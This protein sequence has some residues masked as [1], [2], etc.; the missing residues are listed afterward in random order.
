MQPKVSLRDFYV[1]TKLDQSYEDA[2]L[3]IRPQVWVD[4]KETELKNYTVKAQLYDAENNPVLD[5]MPSANLHSIYYERWPQR[6]L[7]KFGLLSAKVRLPYKWTA[8]TPYLY[9]LVLEVIDNNNKVIEARSQK[10]GF[11]KVEFSKDNELLI[12]GKVTEI[13]GVNRHDHSAVNG[14]ALTREEME[15][16]VKLLK[17]YNFNSVRTSHYP[18]DPYFLELCNEYGIYVMDEANIETHHLGSYMP[19]QPM[20]AGAM[21]SRIIRMVER[22]KNNPSIISWSLGNEAGTGPIFAAAAGWIKDF[23]PTRFIH[24]EGAQG[25]PTHPLYDE[26]AAF[27]MGKS[28]GYANPDDPA[29][30]D[31]ISRMYP[32]LSQLVSM[33]ENG[34]MNRPIIMCEY[35]HAMGNSM[36]GLHDYWK[37]I[38]SR[39]NL[40]G[41]YIWDMIDQ[42]IERTHE[43]GQKYFAYGGDFGD[44]PNDGSFCINGVFSADRKPHPHAFE[45]KYLFQP[46]V[47][48]LVKGT[49]NKVYVLNRFTHSDLNQYEVRWELHQDGKILNKGI[50]PTIHLA[51]GTSKIVEIGFK[52]PKYNNESDYM[53]R[54]SLHEKQDRLWCEAG[55]EIAKEKMVIKKGC[56][57]EEYSSSSKEKIAAKDNDD[58]YQVSSKNNTTTIDKNSGDITS[59]VV[60]GKEQLFAPI[61]PNF[62]RP[63]I[64]NDNRG[65][66]KKYITSLSRFWTAYTESLEVESV[67]VVETDDQKSINIEV[68]AKP[69]KGISLIRNYTI[70]NDGAVTI[71]MVIESPKTTPDMIRFGVTLGISPAL[72]KT[73]Y[74]GYGPHESYIDRCKSVELGAYEMATS[75]IYH[76]YVVPQESG[77]RTG[78][79]RVGFGDKKGKN[80]I[81]VM[82]YPSFEFSAWP[83]TAENI[84]SA[85]KTYNLEEA[86]YYTVNIGEVQAGVSGTLSD[87]LP[88]YHIESTKRNLKFTLKF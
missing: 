3:E 7:P 39:K 37:E 31:V 26:N 62:S 59:I 12:N 49:T 61:K 44:I 73:S 75:D 51:A 1:K 58:S 46:V 81:E 57:K 33:S 40:I 86:G 74:Y 30:V 28:E 65:S 76:N 15:K 5:S 29:F 32:E 35:M 64:E 19:N 54:L 66:S 60:G 24:Y 18:N 68:V 53:L 87:I 41:G 70:H 52:E 13:I 10:I 17:Q 22:D 79:E 4:G 16:D 71:E 84:A 69:Y 88:H 34:H 14:K 20:W 25:D 56:K 27:T 45:A 67:N 72:V 80:G 78:V 9:T 48:E 82:G 36:G 43:N 83:Y 2:T 77:N 38:R 55:Y 50:V 85:K 47:F 23:D 11:R 6:D 21:M 8:E 42:G 63:P